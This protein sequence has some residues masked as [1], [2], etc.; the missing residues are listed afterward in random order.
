LGHPVCVCPI[1]LFQSALVINFAYA[2][3][4]MEATVYSRNCWHCCRCCCDRYY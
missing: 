4:V 3:T 2:A 1:G